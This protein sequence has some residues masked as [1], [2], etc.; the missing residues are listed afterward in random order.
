MHK[1]WYP[2]V[3]VKWHVGEGEA[4]PWDYTISQFRRCHCLFLVCTIKVADAGRG[5]PKKQQRQ[6]EPWEMY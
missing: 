6:V 2:F 1:A 5:E 4:Y 3:Y